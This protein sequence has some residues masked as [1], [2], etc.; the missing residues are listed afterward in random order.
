MSRLSVI[1]PTH[2]PHPVRLR[3]TLESL[4]AQS[5][6]AQDWE[7]IVVDNISEPRITREIL[8][9]ALTANGRIVVEPRLGLSSARAR[10]FRES[11]GDSIVLVDDD[12]VLGPDYLQRALTL[13]DTHPEIGLLGGKSIPEF[14]RAP[15][16]WQEEFFPLLAL[17]DLGSAALIS[18]PA[19]R[20]SVA[21]R[22]YPPFAPIGAGMVL[23]RRAAEAWLARSEHNPL[24]DRRGR[25][26]SSGG[27]NDIVLCALEAGW[28]VA[29][30]PDLSLTHLIPASRL[31]PDYL[32][33]LNRGI[34][35]SWMQ[36]LTLH[37]ANPWAPLSASGALLRSAKAW[38]VHRPWTSPV[39]RIRYAGARGH[40]EGRVPASS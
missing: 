6:D 32:A 39:A 24:S 14:E 4:A 18:E 3:R 36:V 34:Q 1:V 27:D 26:L 37:D 31:A 19:S 2:N 9:P 22:T 38:F 35:K 5:L 17:R 25:E 21:R 20:E 13:L 23:R 10:G 16:A 28:R 12:N 8:P 30:F 7:L 15:A 29:Y 33:R 11:T 40:F